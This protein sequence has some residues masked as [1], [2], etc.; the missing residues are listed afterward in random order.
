VRWENR[1]RLLLAPLREA[2]LCAVF[3]EKGTPKRPIHQQPRKI[4]T[5]VRKKYPQRKE[6]SQKAEKS[7]QRPRPYPATTSKSSDSPCDGLPP[8]AIAQ[9]TITL[10]QPQPVQP[11]MLYYAQVPMES[12]GSEIKPSS[13]RDQIDGFAQ[14]QM[15]SPPQ[16]Q[17]GHADL[18]ALRG[19]LDFNDYEDY[20][21][22]AL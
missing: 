9:N 5:I 6:S 14:H 18:Q 1:D 21:D 10:Q 3:P 7:R 19:F 17:V 12:K 22:S 4:R 15:I 8:E 16:F 11:Q 20:Y 13:Q 2:L